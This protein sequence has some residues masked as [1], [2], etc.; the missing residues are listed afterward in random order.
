M[1]VQRRRRHGPALHRAAPQ[2]G[3]VSV[4]TNIPAEWGV[5]QNI[6]IGV[7]QQNLDPPI[8]AIQEVTILANNWD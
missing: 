5:G 4:G 2:P 6:R 1:F 3:G 7:G 8:E